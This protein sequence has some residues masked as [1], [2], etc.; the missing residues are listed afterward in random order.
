MFFAKLVNGSVFNFSTFFTFGKTACVL[1]SRVWEAA[2]WRVFGRPALSFC[3]QLLVSQ[4]PTEPLLMIS[5][6]ASATV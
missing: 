4:L 6:N 1:F 5:G 2:G 3:Y